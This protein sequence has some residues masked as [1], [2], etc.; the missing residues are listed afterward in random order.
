MAR[1]RLLVFLVAAGCSSGSAPWGPAEG[2]PPD[3]LHD[4]LVAT[5]DG[6]LHRMTATGTVLWSEHLLGGALVDAVGRKAA[7][8]LGSL[9]VIASW[10]IMRFAPA[11]A[12]DDG[13][14]AALLAAA[15]AP[16]AA[17]W[18]PGML[19]LLGGANAPKGGPNED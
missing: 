4:V 14:S 2:L 13:G 1:V 16:S 10:L 9:G 6:T 7:L 18:T 3:P 17:L 15:A 19:M 8:I 5:A 11:A 12:H